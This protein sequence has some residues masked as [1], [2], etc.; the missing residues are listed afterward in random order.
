MNNANKTS[1]LSSHCSHLGCAIHEFKEGKF[2]CPC[3]GS[4][5]TLDGEAVKGPAYKPLERMDF[6]FDDITKS[7]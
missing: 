2:I 6:E 7:F 3:H 1:V 5:F 4:E